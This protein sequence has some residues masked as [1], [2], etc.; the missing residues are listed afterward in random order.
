MEKIAVIITCHNR[1]EKTQRCIKSIVYNSNYNFDFYIT[2]DNSSDG[3]YDMLNNLSETL[4][5]SAYIQRGDG[6]LFW[7][8]GM[9]KSF[10]SAINK[11][12]DLYLWVNDDVEFYEHFIEKLIDVYNIMKDENGVIVVGSCRDRETGELTYGGMKNVGKREKGKYRFI[13]PL[14]KIQ[15]CDTMNGNCVLIDKI[16]VN[17]IGSLDGDYEHAMGDLDYGHRAIDNGVN[18]WISP[19][20]VGTCSRNEITNTWKDCNLSIKKR[21]ELVKKP[22]G[23]PV[24][25]WK[26]YNKRFGGRL[27]AINFIKPYIK[28]FLTSNFL[29]RK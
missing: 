14:D 4:N 20:Y 2:D 24:K 1:R 21:L 26:K 7:C 19:G 11:E 3:T 15:E 9:K 18:I 29:F 5:L 10:D 16:T 13:T 27:W 17:K 23:L 28:I 6:N 12:Y 22:T 25:S 8:K